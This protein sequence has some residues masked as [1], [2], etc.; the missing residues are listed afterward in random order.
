MSN[1]MSALLDLF[2]TSARERRLCDRLHP[3]VVYMTVTRIFPQLMA[4]LVQHL[5]FTFKLLTKKH[6]DFSDLPTRQTFRF[7]NKCISW[8]LSHK[9]T[10]FAVDLCVPN[11]KKLDDFGDLRAFPLTPS[12]HILATFVSYS[13]YYNIYNNIFEWCNVNSKSIGE[14][15]R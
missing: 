6:I 14:L 12:G 9:H 15:G 10:L 4:W 11:R 7:S 5:P 3:S 8:P 2:I 13:N 1:G